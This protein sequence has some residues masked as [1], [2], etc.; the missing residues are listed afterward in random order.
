MQL[1]RASGILLHPTS[2]SSRF[3]VGDFGPNAYEFVDFLANTGQKHWQMLPLGQ[4]G[5]GDS[6]Y[7]S[8]S[9]FAGN[10]YLISPE[11]LV[12]HGF[13]NE[14]DI[15]N[16]PD[17]PA[18]H[19]DYG[20]AIDYKLGILGKAF[21]NFKA[22]NDES[23]VAE[24]HKFCDENGFWLEDYALFR[25]LKLS[26]DHRQWG[27]W[28][29]A[30]KMREPR[31]IAD[32]RKEH[33]EEIFAQK[34][35]QFEFFRQFG[36]LKAYANENGVTLIGDLAIYISRDSAD[37]WCNPAEFKLNES[38]SPTVVSGVPPDAF[39]KT[40]Q[41]WGNPI[42]DWGM[43][44]S[45]G[46]R[47][48]ITRFAAMLRMF[49]IIRIDH[50]IGFTRAWEVPGGDETAEN[51]RWAEVPGK[52]LFTQIQRALGDVPMIVEDLGEV[53]PEVEDLRDTFELPGMKILQFAFGGDSDNIH[54]PHNYDRNCVVYTGTHDSD[55]A[56]GWY[57]ARTRKRGGNPD[58]ADLCRRYLQTDGKEIHWDFIRA[59]LA[60]TAN[61]AIIPLQDVLG[62]DNRAR[63]NIPATN[64][65][66]WQWRFKDGQIRE[67]AI[68]RLREM[69]A[70]YGR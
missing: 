41:L 13:L 63:M 56:R 60:S 18:G 59:A 29:Q 2:L 50:F 69:T 31:T 43:M 11:K 45:N 37:V 38:L 1:P 55:T 17:F 27:D 62:L 53:T 49:D 23:V 67:D 15:Q 6:P 30:L 36:A 4:T 8:F 70:L 7:S 35:Y 39:S 10:I 19:V 54:R 44:R 52:E 28:D 16:P 5:Y 12:E 20:A 64:E 21:D 24:F 26:L 3:G 34:F 48:W 51:G 65:G 14:D 57:K 22:T 9:A 68:G 46:Y 66:N 40:G 47:W 33:D 32:A 58:E 61:T 42:Y 25:A